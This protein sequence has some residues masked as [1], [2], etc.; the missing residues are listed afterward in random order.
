MV[1]NQEGTN[2]TDGAGS[3]SVDG[4]SILDGVDRRGFL[5]HASSAG[6]GVSLLEK[7]IDQATEKGRIRF[8]NAGIRYRIEDDVEP[9]FVDDCAPSKWELLDEELVFYTHY[10]N[11]D[12]RAQLAAGRTVVAGKNV[13]DLPAGQVSLAQPIHLPT[14]LGKGLQPRRGV[15]FDSSYSLPT[16]RIVTAGKDIKVQFDRAVERVSPGEEGV[17]ELDAT[18]VDLRQYEKRPAGDGTTRGEENE[19]DVV[20]E[21][22]VVETT[23]TPE[24]RVRNY[25]EMPFYTV[26]DRLEVN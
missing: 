18:T 3:G 2:R 20:Y 6:A 26:N 10:L 14:T 1:C 4:E 21:S 5:K 15:L 17:V 16:P 9:E 23:V 11:G 12:E 25:G 13:H 19:A 7:R 24:V 22:T 8:G